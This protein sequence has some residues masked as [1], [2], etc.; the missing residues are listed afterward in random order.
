MLRKKGAPA[1]SGPGPDLER[2]D[3]WRGQDLMSRGLNDLVDEEEERFWWHNRAIHDVY[4]VVNG[5]EV[6]AA[7]DGFLAQPGMAFDSYGRELLIAAPLAV[8]APTAPAGGAGERSLRRSL[9]LRYPA[10]PISGSCGAVGTRGGAEILWID[11]RKMSIK[12]GVAIAEGLFQMAG[13]ELVFELDDRVQP[14]LSR[15]I[16]RPQLGSG[17]TP[18]PGTA[19]RTWERT[20]PILVGG[21]TDRLE[22]TLRGLEVTVDTA[23]A[24]FIRTPCY[25][26]WLQGNPWQVRRGITPAP[27]PDRIREASWDRFTFDLWDPLST[28]FLGDTQN[29]PT[30]LTSLLNH[31][32]QSLSVCWLGIELED[33]PAEQPSLLLP[34]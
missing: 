1:G 33:V 3:F 34:R 24:G 8:R 29:A 12:T 13:E 10:E 2:L 17:S 18:S 16:A 26:A 23:S 28:T 9:V 15:P 6:T 25:L 4:G 20:I 32:Q 21:G 27:L 5:L 7:G 11:S 19:W 22:M 31:A 14:P 30:Q